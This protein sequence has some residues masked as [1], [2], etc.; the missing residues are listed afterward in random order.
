MRAYVDQLDQRKGEAHGAK[1]RRD[2][3]GRSGSVVGF[4]GWAGAAPG[5][6]ASAIECGSGNLS[7][8]SSG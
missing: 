7:R 4:S 1:E 6:S 2:R 5:A 8:R 3:D